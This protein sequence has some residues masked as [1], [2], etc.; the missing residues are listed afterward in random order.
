MRM[1]SGAR[2]RSIAD[3]VLALKP[4][5]LVVAGSKH[6]LQALELLVVNFCRL[7]LKNNIIHPFLSLISARVGGALKQSGA[8]LLPSR[9]VALLLVLLSL[10]L[11]IFSRLWVHGLVEGGHQRVV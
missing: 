4:S 8:A 3:A 11:L 10:F 2:R 1:R 7:V 5:L 6:A 9:R